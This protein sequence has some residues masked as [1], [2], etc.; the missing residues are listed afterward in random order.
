[1][2]RPE[3]LRRDRLRLYDIYLPERFTPVAAD[4]EVDAFELWP[5]ARALERVRDGM[6][7]K[8]NVNVAL[9]DLFLRSGLI[10]ADGD[11]GRA[12]RDALATGE[13][14]RAG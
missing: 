13:R 5:L 14:Y 8:F 2:Q 9:I 10:D 6:A 12:L 3:G 11:E 4:G 7:F 1:M